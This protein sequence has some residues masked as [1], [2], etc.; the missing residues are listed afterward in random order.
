M[1][2][3]ALLARQ[4]GVRGVIVPSANAAEAAAVDGIEVIG[5]SSL[6]EVVGMFN[7][8]C[9]LEPSAPIDIE[10]L[11]EQCEPK[12]DFAQV[13]GQ[14]AAKR[15]LTVA[16]AGGHNI[17]MIGPAGTGETVSVAESRDHGPTARLK[18]DLDLH[19]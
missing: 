2:S 13:R 19:A 7:G 6:G 4:R 11:V 1:V 16:A 17:L 14:E 8:Q 10:S 18:P 5:V 12:V 3:L 15:A 9:R